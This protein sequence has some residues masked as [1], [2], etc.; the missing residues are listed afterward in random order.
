MESKPEDPTWDFHPFPPSEKRIPFALRCVGCVLVGKF[1]E[2]MRENDFVV[3]EKFVVLPLDL[4]LG[5]IENVVDGPEA[6]TGGKAAEVCPRW[7]RHGI[8][9]PHA[10]D[11]IERWVRGCKVG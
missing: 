4:R 10:F 5:R 3:I 8:P 1:G 9:P 6:V 7:K 11:G 2:S